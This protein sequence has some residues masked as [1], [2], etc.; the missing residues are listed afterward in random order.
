LSIDQDIS[1]QQS[2]RLPIILHGGINSDATVVKS[3]LAFFAMATKKS[4]QFQENLEAKNY[5]DSYF[6]LYLPGNLKI[7]VMQKVRV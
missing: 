3:L 6:R 2:M 4:I 1:L 7:I 5:F